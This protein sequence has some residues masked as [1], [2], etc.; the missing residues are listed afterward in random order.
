[1]SKSDQDEAPVKG[2]AA[3]N[4]VRQVLEHKNDKPDEDAA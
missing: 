2:D 1:M 3:G 4:P